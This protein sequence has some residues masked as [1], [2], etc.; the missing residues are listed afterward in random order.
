MV[1]RSASG[2][3]C[4]IAAGGTAGHVV[5]ALAI[6]E[7]LQ[8]R[9]AEVTFAGTPGRIEPA[10]GAEAGFAFDSFA[11]A[12]FPRRRRI[13]LVRALWPALRAPLACRRILAERRPDVVLGGG[14]SVAG[15]M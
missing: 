4:L 7:A 5:P 10:L 3:R 12:A 8:A 11:V 1:E 13:G 2:V 15:P 14:G 9:G 6:A